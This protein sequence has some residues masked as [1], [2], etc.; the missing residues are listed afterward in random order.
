MNLYNT[1]ASLTNSLDIVANRVSLINPDGTLA[2][3]SGSS[4]GLTVTGPLTAN[5][6]ITTGTI[7]INGGATLGDPFSSG[8]T[9]Q[10]LL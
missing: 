1:G 8:F 2:S 7:Q 6:G 9:G 4:G 3:I 5:G 10:Q